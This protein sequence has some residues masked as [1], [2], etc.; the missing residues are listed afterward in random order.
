MLFRSATEVKYKRCGKANDTEISMAKTD[1]L[2]V[3]DSDGNIIYRNTNTVSEEKI[4]NLKTHPLSFTSLSLG[5]LAWFSTPV[6]GLF[7]AGAA[8]VCGFLARKKISESPKQFKG[9]SMAAWGIGLGIAAL[10]IA[11]LYL[12]AVGGL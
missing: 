8:I 2:V 7:I 3:K 12:T 11:L 4:A 6:A 5:I 1:I 10:A 9:S